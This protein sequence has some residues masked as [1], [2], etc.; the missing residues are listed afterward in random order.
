MHSATEAAPVSKG[1][2]WTARAM[3]T[4]VV[5]FLLFDAVIHVTRPAPVVEAFEKLGYP[6]S[7]SVG[8][9][10]V[11]LLCVVAYAV[12]GTAILGATLLTGLLGG[13]ISTHVRAGSPPFEAYIFP[14]MMGLL[15]W[16]GLWLRDARL[17]AVFPI[18]SQ[19]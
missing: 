8:I 15:L 3:S 9:G 5:L 17:R 11:E 12:P 7:A 14:L 19:G 2:L 4:L 6:L 10:V 1:R 18:R 13:A 16:G